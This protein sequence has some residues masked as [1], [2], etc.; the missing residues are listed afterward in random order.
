MRL[1][2]MQP[3]FLPYLGYLALIKHSD[4]F[5]IFDTPQFIRHGWIE[6]NR[7][8]K[9]SE[10]WQYIKVPLEKHSSRTAIKDVKIKNTFDWQRKMFAQLDHYKKKAKYYSQVKELLGEVFS[11]KTDSIVKLDAFALEKIFEYLGI[12][13][14][15]S[16][17]SEM[18][19]KIEEPRAPDEWALNI[20]KAMGAN[21]YI[22]LPGG[23]NFFDRN[24][25]EKEGIKLNFLKLNLPEYNQKRKPFEPGLS[26]IDVMIFN[27]PETIRD[28]LNEVEYK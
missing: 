9:P 25:Y 5:V 7:I 6:R 12:N 10:G 3:Y 16:I 4:F 17:F 22:N 2:I 21:E 15:Y 18:N 26:I 24:K 27:S 28:M 23:E 19:L 13:F 20:S 14:N 1:A 8:L 11:F